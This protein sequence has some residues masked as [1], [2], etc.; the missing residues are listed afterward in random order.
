M[1]KRIGQCSVSVANIF[2]MINRCL[3]CNPLWRVLIIP[4]ENVTYSIP[5]SFFLNWK[6]LVLMEW[7]LRLP[8][9]PKCCANIHY[10]AFI[11]DIGFWSPYWPYVGK[12]S[13]AVKLLL[14]FGHPPFPSS[15]ITR[16][17]PSKTYFEE[18]NS[19]KLSIV[20]VWPSSRRYLS[21][22]ALNMKK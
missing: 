17:F 5:W 16:A 20:Y 6:C 7:C 2:R 21:K 15:R 13:S 4:T 22:H 3:S 1:K 14:L 8:R 18:A 9:I 19:L 11:G 12:A 10:K